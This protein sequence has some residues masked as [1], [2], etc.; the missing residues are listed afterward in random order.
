MRPET[1]DLRTIGGVFLA[2]SLLMLCG[3]ALPRGQ[4]MLVVGW[5]GTSEAQMMRMVQAADGSFVEGAGRSWLAVVH[6]DGPGLPARL[7]AEG[8]MIVLD[9]ALAVGCTEGK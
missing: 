9:H 5:P 2:F 8:A 7:M 1:I 6:A 3:V 4:Y